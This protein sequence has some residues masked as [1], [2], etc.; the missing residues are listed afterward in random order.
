MIS[1]AKEWDGVECLRCLECYTVQCPM[2]TS[3]T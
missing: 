2:E 3:N 1:L